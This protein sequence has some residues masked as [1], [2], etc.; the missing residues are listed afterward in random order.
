MNTIAATLIDA[1]LEG[2]GQPGY[3]LPVVFRVAFTWGGRRWQ[4]DVEC[5]SVEH[6]RWATTR[7]ITSVLKE[8]GVS[9]G[10][11]PLQ[12]HIVL[13]D[14]RVSVTDVSRSTDTHPI[15]FRS[16]RR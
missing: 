14:G 13:N 11:L 1:L 12:I 8:N 3:D 9:V 7:A 15:P 10:Q 5:A 2:R 16:R 6:K 4:K